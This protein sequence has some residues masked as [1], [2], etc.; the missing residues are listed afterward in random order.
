MPRTT[1]LAGEPGHL[2]HA[3][4]R[5]DGH[6]E[7]RVIASAEPGTLIGRGEQSIDFRTGEKLDQR[8]RETLAGNSQHTLDLCRVVGDI[9]LGETFG[10]QSAFCLSPKIFHICSI[11]SSPRPLFPSA[12]AK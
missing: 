12:Y 7:K 8:P 5:L 3:K 10:F 9:A 1:V 4:A 11:R 6:Q 2:G